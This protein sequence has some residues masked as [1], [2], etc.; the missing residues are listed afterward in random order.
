[1]T[2]LAR[3][4]SIRRLRLTIP[5]YLMPRLESVL[6]AAIFLGVIGLGPRL[7]NQ[8]GDLGR[9]LT[10]GSYILSNHQIPTRDL[11]SHT[12]QGAALTP[13]EWLA[14]VILASAYQ[15]AGLN[16]V[17][18][19]C[20]L[21]LAVS[22]ALVYRQ[23]MQRSRMVI[24]S[25][26]FSILA[27][28]AASLHWLARPHLFTLLL[29]VVWVGLLE[30]MRRGDQRYWWILPVLMLVWANL[31]GAFIVGFVI[32]GAYLLE[33]LYQ[34]R[35]YSRSNMLK[36]AQQHY[37]WHR[38]V[39]NRLLLVG[40]LS[41]L[42]TLINPVGIRLWG[43]SFGF[44]L[45]RYLVGHTAE[46]LPVNF[47][48]ASTWPFLL[49]LVLSIILLVFTWRRLNL[50]ALILLVGW[51]MAGLLSLRNIPIYAVIAAP[52]LAEISAHLCRKSES[53]SAFLR[54]DVRLRLV[55]NS[56]RGFVWP[57]I[58]LILV[59]AALIGGR[60]LDFSHE[61]NRFSPQV[62]PVMAADW[63]KSNPQDGEVFNY[64]PWG[65]Y[66]LYRLWPEKQVFIDGQTD[67]YGEA[68]TRQ[69][70]QVI[71][72]QPGWQDI[73]AQHQVS[74]MLLPPSEALAREL[75]STPGWQLRYQD[76]TAVLI[77]HAP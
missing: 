44:L 55:E 74:W 45:N 63:L 40:G 52:I 47:Q 33:D 77:T 68:L 8:D 25:I 46:Y 17:V 29:V 38:W 30:Q 13:H 19:L 15:L 10:I 62:F 66:L 20:A 21:L 24:L 5:V 6:F 23:C 50:A 14:Q 48:Q 39:N 18:Y 2:A 58:C 73:L 61:G 3:S 60:R 56:L 32:L 75:V 26:G 1:M 12:M 43:T 41:F 67:F 64:F 57:L 54:F 35:V 28:A 42:A 7:L 69:Y 34:K 16:G 4:L 49:M 27:A 36:A 11:F 37:F 9:H 76:Q 70:E 59:A 22:I 31:H 51:S 53:F 72:L 71:T 65:G